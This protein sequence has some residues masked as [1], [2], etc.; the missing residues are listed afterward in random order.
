MKAHHYTDIVQ[1]GRLIQADALNEIVRSPLASFFERFRDLWIDFPY[2][3][4]PIFRKF[5]S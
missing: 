1:G 5:K 2:R 3:I 4:M